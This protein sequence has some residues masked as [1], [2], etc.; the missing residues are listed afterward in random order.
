MKLKDKDIRYLV[1]HTSA[2]EEASMEDLWNWHVEERGWSD[3]GYHYYIRKNGDIKKGRNDNTVGAHCR[4]S[5]MNFKSLGICFEGHHDYEEWTQ[6]Q[7]ISFDYLCNKLIKKYKI[8]KDNIIGHREAYEQDPP[9]KTCPGK[10]IDMDLVRRKYTEEVEKL[11][12]R[13]LEFKQIDII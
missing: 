1:I 10:K 12:G 2:A 6:D 4:A 11:Q 5:R 7:K 13:D 3:V 9:P 8:D